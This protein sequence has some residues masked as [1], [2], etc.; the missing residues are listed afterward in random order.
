MGN[1]ADA[2]AMEMLTTW[3]DAK[4]SRVV[5]ISIHRWNPDGM[6][7]RVGLRETQDGPEVVSAW[8]SAL[9]YALVATGV[10]IP[11]KP[12]DTEAEA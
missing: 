7:Y 12:L 4:Q 10:G 3:A 11:E 5:H 9:I 2:L 8:G 1:P 6:K